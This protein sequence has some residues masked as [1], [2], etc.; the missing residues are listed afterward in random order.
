MT[1]YQYGH[2]TIA[3][4]S[5]FPLPNHVKKILEFRLKLLFGEGLGL[6]TREHP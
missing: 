6:Q 3:L 1:N 5:I 4:M 2:K